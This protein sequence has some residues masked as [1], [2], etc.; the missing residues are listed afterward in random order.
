MKLLDY[1]CQDPIYVLENNIPIDTEYY[2]TNQLSNPL[3]RIFEPILGEKKAST[4]LLR[5]SQKNVKPLEPRNSYKKFSLSF[6]YDPLAT[7]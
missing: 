6:V 2:L 1:F 4:D 7:D 5:E 3:L